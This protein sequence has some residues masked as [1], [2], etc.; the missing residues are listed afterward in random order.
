[1]LSKSTSENHKFGFLNYKYDKV[2][3]KKILSAQDSYKCLSK[4][5]WGVLQYPP[6]KQWNA[7]ITRYVLR[8]TSGIWSISKWT[9]PPPLCA[10][11]F[12]YI[13]RKNQLFSTSR[14]RIHKRQKTQASGTFLNVVKKNN[15]ICTHQAH[16]EKFDLGLEW[17]KSDADFGGGSALFF[18]IRSQILTFF[19]IFCSKTNVSSKRRNFAQKNPV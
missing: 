13:L 7:K 14:S 9:W 2:F 8:Q 15:S 5:N 18:W 16:D 11:K 3:S 4:T 1:M 17:K 19:S 6:P 12:C 10:P